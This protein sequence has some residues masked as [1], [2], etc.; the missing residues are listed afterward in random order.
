LQEE[1]FA[2]ALVHET[3][4]LHTIYNST[5]ASRTSAGVTVPCTVMLH[6]TEAT[7]PLPR[8]KEIMRAHI[9]DPCPCQILMQTNCDV[10]LPEFELQTIIGGSYLWLLGDD[11]AGVA[12][13]VA[14]CDNADIRPV[15]VK[16]IRRGWNTP[17]LQ[18]QA[19][20]ASD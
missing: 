14:A 7:H 2:V 18:A 13:R 4:V 20:R 15:R 6:L 8:P 3:Q 12:R 1:A 9:A 11:Q 5:M 16:G 10:D 17:G 19:L